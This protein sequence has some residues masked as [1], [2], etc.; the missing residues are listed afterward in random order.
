MKLLS[1]RAKTA[2]NITAPQVKHVVLPIMANSPWKFRR[3]HWNRTDTV[4]TQL[5][6]Q[7]QKSTS[8]KFDHIEELAEYLG[9]INSVHLAIN[10]AVLIEAHQVFTHDSPCGEV[11]IPS[12]LRMGLSN[13]TR[14]DITP[15]F[16]WP[17]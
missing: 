17:E 10:E 6:E 13:N 16:F 11:Y 14:R 9:L 12:H 5:K 8:I 3:I 2:R 15:T 1:K 7:H 4:L